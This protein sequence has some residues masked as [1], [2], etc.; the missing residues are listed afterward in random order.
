MPPTDRASFL[1]SIKGAAQTRIKAGAFAAAEGSKAEI[2][3]L[4]GAIAKKYGGVISSA[5]VKSMERASEK[6]GADYGGDWYGIKDLA[7]MTIVVPTISSVRNV[8]VDLQ[9]TFRAS[10]GRGIIQVKEVTGDMDPCGYSSTTVF[11]RTSNDRPAEV[12]INIP[13]IIY[14]KQGEDSVKRILGQQW[15]I[16][17]KMKY[18]LV[19]GMGHALYEVYRVAPGSPRA[20]AAASLSKAYYAYFR[21]GMPNPAV[22]KGLAEQLRS[23]GPV[24]H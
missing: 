24:H 17:I 23:F 1:S 21:S 5:P 13:E 7:R 4:G 6:V 18:G 3:A 16:N 9:N 14:A 15:Y 11:V 10:N 22:A 12:Q 19:G 8:L 20:Q 2:E